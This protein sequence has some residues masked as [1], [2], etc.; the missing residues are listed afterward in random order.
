MSSCADGPCKSFEVFGSSSPFEE[1]FAKYR[2]AAQPSH[3]RPGCGLPRSWCGWGSN[4][5][6]NW[7]R[8]Q[9]HSLSRGCSHEPRHG[10]TLNS[11]KVTPLLGHEV[12][13][14]MPY[15][16]WKGSRGRCGH[17]FDQA[18]L[19]VALRRSAIAY[20]LLALLSSAGSQSPPDPG[21]IS[22]K[23]DSGRSYRCFHSA[24]FS[25]NHRK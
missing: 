2:S 13:Q 21:A 24:P 4:C 11:G 1:S 22:S 17:N 8:P 14:G 10:N 7:S 12:M 6:T 15:T 3:G 19:S 9:R 25:L 18:R 23:R 20:G 5:T 16:Y